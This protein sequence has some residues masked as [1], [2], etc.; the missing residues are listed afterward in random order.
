MIQILKKMEPWPFSLQADP[1]D[2]DYTITT[3]P[4][5]A[6]TMVTISSEDVAPPVVPVASI[7]VSNATITESDVTGNCSAVDLSSGTTNCTTVTVS[8]DENAPTGG[9]PVMVELT[10]GGANYAATLGMDYTVGITV[11][12]SPFTVTVP[13]SQRMVSFMVEAMNDAYVEEDGTLTFALQTGAGYTVNPTPEMASAVVTIRSDDM[14]SLVASIAVNHATITENGTDNCATPVTPPATSNCTTV[15]VS[16]EGGNAP[17]GGVEVMVGLTEGGAAG[18]TT[19]TDDYTVTGATVTA[20]PSSFTVT[21]LE[22]TDE[23]SFTIMAVNDNDVEEDGT[24]SFALRPGTDYTINPTPDM[25]SAEV[26]I[27]SEDVVASIAVNNATITEKDGTDDCAIEVMSPDTTNCTT[28]TV[29]LG[30]DAPTGGLPVMIA[31]TAGGPAGTTT[32]GADGDYT[33]SG[34]TVDPSPFMVTVLQGQREASFTIMAVNDDYVEGDGTLS[35][36]LQ[37][38]T[39]YIVNTDSDL[40][41]VEITIS[42]D[43][44]AS[45]VAS[46]SANNPTI[47]EGVATERCADLTMTTNCTIV[48]V[49]L[50]GGDAPTGGVAV[51]I[52][53]TTTT[54][55]ADDTGV[56]DAATTD[57]YTVA[58]VAGE[59]MVATSSFTVTVPEM[60]RMAS[61][62]ITAMDDDIGEANGI[63][64]FALYP[65]IGYAVTT[66]TTP[67]NSASVMVTIVSEDL[68]TVSIMASSTTISE[69]G[70]STTISLSAGSL[71][72][73]GTVSV[74]VSRPSLTRGTGGIDFSSLIAATTYDH[75]D[76]TPQDVEFSP[77]D[78]AIT[79]TITVFDEPAFP[80]PPVD[81][82]NGDMVFE[83]LD[84]PDYT[85][86]TTND[87][88]TVTIEDNDVPVAGISVNNT[89]ITESDDDGDCAVAVSTPDTTNCTTVTVILDMIT[90]R[91]DG[92]PVMV[93]LAAGGAADATML[94]SDYT[95]EGAMEFNPSATFPVTVPRGQTMEIMGPDGTM[96]MVSFASFTIRTVND[97]DFEENG[98][99]AFSLQPDPGNDDYTVTT[100]PGDASAL[101]LLSVAMTPCQ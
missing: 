5:D 39:S 32:L 28:V 10:A 18:S 83:I 38:G 64:T 2:D 61:F 85:A 99:L 97:T 30:G 11:D 77:E 69:A 15:T 93:A 49:R 92:V 59:V 23:I 24:L 68:P 96:I 73:P 14:A 26:T 27:S 22:N 74:R 76:D 8:L 100:T 70:G 101:W 91:E 62:T 63:M 88:A 84:S 52:R 50:T 53:H 4:G 90:Q 65:G 42:S 40:A 3:T 75:E 95:V 48:T 29:S 81:N 41:S 80:R 94:T 21:V 35:F 37:P 86:S 13:E 79:F 55:N 51:M 66:G 12:P 87:T 43:D 19:L 44:M 78:G 46:I 17:M 45:L 31:L 72:L 25:A 57:D 47:T 67:P 34:A 56:D 89:T 20:P 82:D 98:T 1:G 60:E 71:S 9:L 7:A 33:V 6:S 54:V 16:L 58:A 36:A